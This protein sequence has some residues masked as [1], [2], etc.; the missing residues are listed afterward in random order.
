MKRVATLA[1]GV[2][3]LACGEAEPEARPT[4]RAVAERPA[5]VADLSLPAAPA[6]PV[7]DVVLITI[8]TLR[9]DVLGFMG[10]DEV[11]TP[12]LDRLSAG[13][14]TFDNARAHNVLTLPSHANILTGLHPYEH[15]IRDNKGFVLPATLPT[16][17]TLLGGAGFATGAFVAA[18]PLDSRYGLDRGFEVYDDDYAVGSVPTQIDMP[19]RS[20]E[21][22]VARALDWWRAHRDERRFLWVHLYEP[23]SP[24]L[25]PE[26]F[27]SRHRDAP[28]RGEVEAVDHFLTPLLE[29]FLGGGEGPT[30]VVVTSDHGEALGE[31]GERSHGLFAYEATIKAPLV[32]WGGGLGTGRTDFPASHV[33]LLPTML[34]AAGVDVPASVSGQALFADEEPSADVSQY[35][36]SLSPTFDSGFAPL[37]G[38]V[39]DGYKFISLPLPELYDLRSDPT[40][41]RNLVDSE[42]DHLRRLARLLPTESV[43]PPV[44]GEVSAE[45]EQAL[46][47]LGYLTGSA[48]AK[49]SYGPEDDPKNLVVLDAKLHQVTDAMHLGDPAGAERLAREVIAERPSMGLAWFLLAQLVL[50]RGASVEAIELMQEAVRL[51]VATD[52]LRRQ[53][54]LTLADV[55]RYPEALAVL[56]PFGDSDDPDVLNALALV[57]STAGRQ[58]EA[59]AALERI[60]ATDGRNALALQNLA[61]VALRSQRWREAG[62]YAERALELDGRLG[63]AWNYLGTARY[64]TGDPRGAV[65]AW[66]RSI[67]VEPENYDALYNLALVA[68]QI[69]ETGRARRALERFVTSAPSDRYAADIEKARAMLRQLPG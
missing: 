68:A 21:E 6:A 64:N 69:G 55:G 8:D 16:A 66:E 34:R 2:G 41:S 46:R 19:E 1:L 14:W 43:W 59:R 30:L 48:A 9:A 63:Q 67:A 53:L 13:G 23:H 20:G 33:D 39:H 44:R 4:G 62:G 26:P 31:H 56:E 22:V 57:L 27:A 52:S 60:L 18:F 54:G 61:L 24:Y 5:A 47:S 40:E 12:T 3:L 58:P 42:R 65:D 28:Y 35:F 15:G 37:R 50:D 38:V 32:L 51:G 17:A 45:A 36:E 11:A 29:P 7:R 25:P 10:S 49:E